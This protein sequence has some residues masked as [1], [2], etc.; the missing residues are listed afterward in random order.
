MNDAWPHLTKHAREINLAVVE[1]HRVAISPD[2]SERKLGT[3][4]S[5]ESGT[6]QY[7]LAGC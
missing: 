1:S 7:A 2:D 4:K 6:K 5:S 3:D